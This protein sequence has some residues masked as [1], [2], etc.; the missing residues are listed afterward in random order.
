M[1]DILLS[2]L[3]AVNIA[4]GGAVGNID[5]NPDLSDDDPKKVYVYIVRSGYRAG[6]EIKQKRK[7]ERFDAYKP[8]RGTPKKFKEE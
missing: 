4:F 5:L 1:L 7:A 8:L 3:M 6:I 2:L